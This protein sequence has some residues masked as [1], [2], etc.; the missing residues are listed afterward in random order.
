MNRSDRPAVIILAV[1][2]LV[3]ILAATGLP[4]IWQHVPVAP[5]SPA[6]VQRQQQ[7]QLDRQRDAV[8]P[9]APHR[10]AAV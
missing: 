8:E 10:Y 5:W 6:G 1:C 3:F 7:E 4:T 9:S 2:A